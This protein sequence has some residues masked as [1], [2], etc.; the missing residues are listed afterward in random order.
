MVLGC[1]SMNWF[2]LR[3][4][5][6]SLQTRTKLNLTAARRQTFAAAMGQFEEQFTAAKV[7]TAATRPLNLYY[8]LAIAR[9]YADDPWSALSRPS[10]G[11]A[12][13]QLRRMRALMVR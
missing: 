2:R 6:S 8:A 7:V 3:E 4:R 11:G 9:A 13:G 10:G 5:R 12:G 1:A